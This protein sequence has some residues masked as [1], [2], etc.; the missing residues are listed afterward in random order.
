MFQWLMNM[1]TMGILRLE[2]TIIKLCNEV[3]KEVERLGKLGKEK[4]NF[5]GFFRM[6]NETQ[7]ELISFG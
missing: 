4:S 5:K 2:L 6:I 7:N 1:D 3:R